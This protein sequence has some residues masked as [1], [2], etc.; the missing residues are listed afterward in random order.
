MV[1]SHA[2]PQTSPSYQLTLDNGVFTLRESPEDVSDATVTT[3]ES[4]TNDDVFVAT[5]VDV[6]GAEGEVKTTYQIVG[7]I[8]QPT[9]TVL[10]PPTGVDCTSPL[11]TRGCKSLEIEYATS[12][13]ADRDRRRTV[14]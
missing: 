9:L 8:A 1:P 10:D 5:S 4:P 6:G 2:S 12:T 3:F 13:T 11:L 7:G 14:G